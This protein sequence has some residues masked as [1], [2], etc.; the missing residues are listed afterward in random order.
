MEYL[1]Y[2]IR[3]IFTEDYV[4]RKR[5]YPKGSKCNTLNGIVVISEEGRYLFD[6][7]SNLAR[8]YGKIIK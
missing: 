2:G 3:F 7:D 6:V 1:D 4:T 8:K 5:N